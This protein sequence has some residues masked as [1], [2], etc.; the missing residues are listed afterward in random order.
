[1]LQLKFSPFVRYVCGGLFTVFC[2]LN[3]AKG[4]SQ[5]DQPTET[6]KAIIDLERSLFGGSFVVRC[7]HETFQFRRG[8]L[9]DL[10]IQK[11]DNK[12][13]WSDIEVISRDAHSFVISRKTQIVTPDMINNSLANT[14]W[15][16]R[17][18]YNNFKEAYDQRPWEA[19][20]LAGSNREYYYET[21]RNLVS[22]GE[23]I[24]YNRM[25]TE[26]VLN[27]STSAYFRK[28]SYSSADVGFRVELSALDGLRNSVLSSSIVDD[29][30]A[31]KN[32]P[33]LSFSVGSQMFRSG[34]ELRWDDRWLFKRCVLI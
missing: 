28:A 11:P 25:K 8:I 14:E 24:L 12:G 1:M 26:W 18:L 33:R 10:V 16:G 4:F 32:S 23:V 17:F 30:D 3:V 7:G 20:W 13:G 5:T 21:F 2:F 15:L 19:D 29:S 31:W 34:D 6:L 9:G 22:N 27:L